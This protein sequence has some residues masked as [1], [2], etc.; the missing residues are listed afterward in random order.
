MMYG[1]SIVCTIAHLFEPNRQPD[2]KVLA[3]GYTYLFLPFK[4]DHRLVSTK[5]A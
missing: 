2:K 1:I 4:R 3:G 5:L